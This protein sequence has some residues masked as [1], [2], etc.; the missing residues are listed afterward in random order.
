MTYRFEVL[1]ENASGRASFIDTV[2]VE[3]SDE[4]EAL[5]KVAQLV[6]DRTNIRMVEAQV[7]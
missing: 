3:A 6:T 7:A 5:E 2:E 4:G 1:W